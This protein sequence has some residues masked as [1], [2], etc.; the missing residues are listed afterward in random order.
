MS[1][2][3]LSR[4]CL[5]LSISLW[6]ITVY[7]DNTPQDL[8]LRFEKGEVI[9]LNQNQTVLLKTPIEGIS[10]VMIKQ[11]NIRSLLIDFKNKNFPLPISY[12]GDRNG[13]TTIVLKQA[14]F[15]FI[16]HQIN[17]KNKGQLFWDK[18]SQQAHFRYQ[19]V[20]NV[21]LEESYPTQLIVEIKDKADIILETT[22]IPQQK[23]IQS[24]TG[25]ANTY[26]QSLAKHPVFLSI[27]SVK[28][29]ISQA[30]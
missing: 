21:Y 7:A 12:H 18:N 26:Y 27:Y 16:K 2:L 20:A 22:A 11:G 14:P 6:T 28:K 30:E 17:G 3:T 4:Y 5:L 25:G 10:G 1:I 24:R 8:I 19:G 15:Q 23:R 13:Q 29:H 9:L